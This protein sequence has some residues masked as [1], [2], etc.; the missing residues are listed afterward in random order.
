M[1][2]LTEHLRFVTPHRRDYLDICETIEKP[3]RKNGVLGGLYL[4]NGMDIPAW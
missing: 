3:V 2:S 4:A 1:K